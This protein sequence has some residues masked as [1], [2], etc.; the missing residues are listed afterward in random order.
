M[1][2]FDDPELKNPKVLTVSIFNYPNYMPTIYQ[3]KP[4]FQNILRPFV[5]ILAKFGVTPNQVTILALILS[6]STG[7][8]IYL[9]D[10]VQWTLLALPIVLFVRM[11]LNAIDGM[12][13]KEYNMKSSLG[14]LMNEVGDVISD[15]ALYLPF[16][17]IP[18]TSP[19]LVVTFVI[20]A[21]VCE[22]TGVVGVQ[23]GASRRYDGPMGKS[24]RA[25]AFGI[26]GVLLGF[27]LKADF[28][29]DMFMGVLV[30]LLFVTIFNRGR[31]A[32]KE[33]KS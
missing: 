27:G 15:M 5:N 8:V 33:L 24:D 22:L 10:F 31:N 12:L 9:T 2:E 3:L 25:Y 4:S 14:A 11:A 28:W 29:Y 7:L 16:A 19:I 21:V 17:F 23:I 18:N 1:E 13:A 26:L 32:I 20:T 30:I 6:I